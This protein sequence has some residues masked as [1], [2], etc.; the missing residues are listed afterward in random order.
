[1]NLRFINAWVLYSLWLVPLLGWW[2]YS[3]G[4]KR[5]AIL[6][7][8]VSAHMQ[9][10]LMPTRYSSRYSWQ[11]WLLSVALLL[12]LIALARPQW[13]MKEEVVYKRGRDLIIAL[14]VSRSM[15]A[16]DVYPNRLQ[17]AKTDLIDLINELKGDRAGLM[18]FRQKA[19]L[20][21]PLTTDYA[22]LMHSLDAADPG[23]APMGR[24]DIGDAIIKAMESFD[25]QESSHKAIILISDGED[26]TGKAQIAAAQA[27]TNG[28]PVFCV[29]IG[30]RRG[31]AIPDNEK[32]GSFVKYQGNKVVTKLNDSTLENIARITGGKYI[33]LGTA[34]TTT[35][36][37]GTLYRDHLKNITD[38]DTEETFQRRHI[39]RFQI[40]LFPA[41]L[42][43]TIAALLS[44]GRLA[45]RKK[46]LATLLLL[47]SLSPTILSAQTTPTTNHPSALSPQSP[48][49]GLPHQGAPFPPGR[50]G[51]RIAQKLYSN[52]KH[53]EAA[54]AYLDA[55]VGS[56]PQSQ[57]DF[58][59]NAAVSYFKAGEYERASE[60][61]RN[62]TKTGS[63]HESSAAMGLGLAQYKD[64]HF[65]E[66]PNVTN[67]TKR[68]ELLESAAES[69][70]KA[71]RT[72]KEDETA[73]RNLQIALYALPDARENA[74][75]ATLLDIH[76]KTQAPELLHQ[77]LEEQRRLNSEITDA[78]TNSSPSR[79]IQLE[80]LAERQN[81]I[82]D[83]WIP[84]KQKLMT[85]AQN[86]DPQNP[87]NQ[88][89]MAALNQM[90]ESTRQSMTSAAGEIRDLSPD[91]YRSSI[92]SEALTYNLWKAIAPYAQ[93][94]SED[95][96]CQ[97]NAIDLNTP[98]R[99]LPPVTYPSTEL[100]QQ[101]AL[102][103]TKLFIDRFSKTVPEK[104]TSPQ[105]SSPSVLRPPSSV[106]SAKDAPPSPKQK[107]ISAE[108]RKEILALA[109]KA[110][111][112][113]TKALKTLNSINP[114][115][116]LIDQNETH[117]ILKEIEK[118]LP[119]EN[120][121]DQQQQQENKDN[122]KSEKNKDKI[123]ED[124]EK[125]EKPPEE[126][127]PEPKPEEPNQD[128]L[129]KLLA[130]ALQREKEHDEKLKKRNTRTTHRLPFEQ[131]W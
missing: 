99:K 32:T 2:V 108:T 130:K 13:G 9:K 103:L 112:F 87:T 12:I 84:L 89:N 82:A 98:G 60:L 17:R 30:S 8:F 46:Q 65:T 27:K 6:A 24:T 95:M 18:A 110:V 25:N 76:N 64:S 50:T 83:I 67:L 5:K 124:D 7:R 111:L 42:L 28:V 45:T 92:N 37:L 68:A 90:I 126:K 97:T 119:K 49:G 70:I 39:E 43:M 72:A 77:M 47:S 101:E 88:Q 36:T 69:F 74:K 58:R 20:L 19:V 127:K 115:I 80:N 23:S 10:T 22:Y 15:L 54:I 129:K 40:F 86:Q 16:T 109:D 122:Q 38:R 79:I 55:A 21:C 31:S 104:G 4:L 63:R 52:G 125:K 56:T 48:V 107:G 113:Q 51:A 121:K 81:A 94:L 85:T 100:H 123:P 102:N 105:P 120:P 114:T 41:F 96:Y 128:E 33:P 34:S 11:V 35:T 59:Y 117:R 29:G 118:L 66:E 62:L 3:L 91:G 106:I 53:K 57:E 73:K 14:D 26:L 75:T 1:M 61:L 71:A 131:D 78:F 44:R 116:A 93:I